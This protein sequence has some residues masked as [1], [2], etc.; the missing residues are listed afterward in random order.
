MPEEI[1]LKGELQLSRRWYIPLEPTITCTVKEHICENLAEMSEG[2]CAGL[3]V[4][5]GFPNGE[6]ALR[7][8]L[9]RDPALCQKN[10]SQS[11]HGKER[12][13]KRNRVR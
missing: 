2:I 9:A 7:S 8:Q 13:A 6:C 12:P 1:Q 3:S 11:N 10:Q 5:I 4:Q